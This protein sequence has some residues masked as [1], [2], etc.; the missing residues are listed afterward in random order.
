MLLVTVEKLP[1]GDPDPRFRKQ[2]ATVEIVNIGGSF[3][4]A[5]YEVR[6]FEEAGNRIATGLLVDYPR[7]ATTVLDLVG[8]GI[9]TALAGSEELPPRPP[10]R[11]RRRST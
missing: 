5:S 3:A 1:Y 11:R 4:S 7:Y 8:R 10:F 6:L 9:V 2:L